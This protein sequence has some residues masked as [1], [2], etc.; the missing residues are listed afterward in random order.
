ML[1][2]SINLNLISALKALLDEANVTRAAKRLNVTQSAMS[3]NLA[4][5]REIFADPLLVR[6][7]NSLVLTERALE[8]R[9][10]VDAVLAEIHS[11]V[12]GE[13]FTPATCTSLFRIATTDYVAEQVIPDALTNMHD[14]APHIRVEVSTMGSGDFERLADRSLDF[15]SCIMEE[16]M[17]GLEHATIGRDRFKCCMRAGHPLR[18]GFNLDEYCEALHAAVT[19]TGDK[20]RPVDNYL[21]QQGRTRRIT[22]SAPLYGSVLEVV[23][24]SDLLLTIPAHIAHNLSFRYGLSV[25]EL[26]FE[27]PEFEYSLFWHSC[28]NAD[29]AHIWFRECLMKEIRLLPA[30]GVPD[31]I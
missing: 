16:S 24:R 9:R 20:I 26:P 6:V 5:L 18:E 7:G 3:R 23:K 29:S 10:R 22:F 13:S 21:M 11:M 4:Q 31:M 27:L 25:V 28:R 15:V 30:S 14:E 8:L 1:L 17:S 12:E 2:S 19:G